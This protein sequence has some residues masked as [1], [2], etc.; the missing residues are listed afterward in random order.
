[1]F[2]VEVAV[3]DD[4]GAE[5]FDVSD[6]VEGSSAVLHLGA[7]GSVEGG[8]GCVSFLGVMG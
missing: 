4:F 8:H 7:G 3:V 5:G 1:M 6:F 2:E